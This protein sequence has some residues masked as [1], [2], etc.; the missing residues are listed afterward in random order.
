M[1]DINLRTVDAGEEEVVVGREGRVGGAVE[2]DVDGVGIVGGVRGVLR[3]ENGGDLIV[4]VNVEGEAVLLLLLLRRIPL[5]NPV[6]PR[7][8]KSVL[9]SGLSGEDVLYICLVRW[10]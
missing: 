8:S 7:A 1:H 4:V 3:M 6:Y 5:H 10:R 2:R 9:W